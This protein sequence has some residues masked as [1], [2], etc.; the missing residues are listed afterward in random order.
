[1]KADI[2]QPSKKVTLTMRAVYDL[3]LE[4][5]AY[6]VRKRTGQNI[7]RSGIIDFLIAGANEGKLVDAISRKIER[8][9]SQSMTKLRA[10]SKEAGELAAEL[11]GKRRR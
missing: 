4:S 10:D 1:M 7:T 2:E 5:I 3:Q 9:F 8:E 6:Q 11:A